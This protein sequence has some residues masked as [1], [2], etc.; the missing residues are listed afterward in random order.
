MPKVSV[1]ITTHNR[2]RLL[3]QAV[4]SVLAQSFQDFEFIIV[5]DASSD[6]T[7]AAIAKFSDVR[8]RYFR[9]VQNRGEAA[10]RNTGVAHASGDYIAFL[11]DDDTWLPEKLAIQ[12]NV[13]DRC[14]A[15]VGGV[16]T[17][18]HRIDIETG[19]IIATVPAEKRGNI[20]AELRG[21]NWV[22]SPSAVLLR[23]EC[24]DKVGRF[25]EEIKF[26]VDYDMWI[27]IS[28]WFDFEVVNEPLMRYAVHP[29][30]LSADS[31]AILHGKEA[32]LA[33]YADYFAGDRRSYG[34]YL[35]SLGVL[36]CYNRK[37]SE[38]RAALRRSI[39]IYPFEMRPYVN[40]FFSL[41]GSE[42][43]IRMKSLKDRVQRSFS[44]A[45]RH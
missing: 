42:N 3:G 35:L 6:D 8:I 43:F 14:P 34:R 38:G 1:I 20:Y 25:D 15:R 32:Q 33:K 18:Y 19:A 26:G 10:C 30:R 21:Q 40:L 5:D 41:W 45:A 27:R 9:H 31:R 39:R 44:G 22:G 13:L 4:A 28:R 24:F 11:D 37:L 12:V 23:R 7:Q 17:G 2:A 36:Y 29:D 16:Y